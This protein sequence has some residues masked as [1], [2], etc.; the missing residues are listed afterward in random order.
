[1]TLGPTT[2]SAGRASAGKKYTLSVWLKS[3][4]G[5]ATV[6]L[7]PEHSADPW[8]G[9]G[10]K[11][12]TMTESWAEYTL[13]TPAFAANVSPASMTFHLGFAPAEFWVDNIRW[14]EGEYVKP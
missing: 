3:K 13:T 4:S 12:V 8:E 14:Y 5:P 7:K 9:Y 11:Q 10:E 6:N 1:M 2:T